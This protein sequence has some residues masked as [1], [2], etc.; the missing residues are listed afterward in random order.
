MTVGWVVVP[1]SGCEDSRYGV[2]PMF[3]D[4]SFQGR[5]SSVAIKR[6]LGSKLS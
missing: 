5:N 1:A 6:N 4:I 3:L 2:I